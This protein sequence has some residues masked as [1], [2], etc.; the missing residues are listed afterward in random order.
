MADF[1]LKKISFEFG[2]KIKPQI[3]VV[4]TDPQSIRSFSDAHKLSTFWV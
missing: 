3:S 2:N 4:A 1:L